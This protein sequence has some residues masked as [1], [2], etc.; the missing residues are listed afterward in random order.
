[1]TAQQR[2]VLAAVIAGV[3][4]FALGAGWQFTSARGYANRLTT[5]QA[6]LTFQRLEATL[7]AATVEA[8]RGSYE[9]A[10]QLASS[11]FTGLQ[12]DL[13][14]AP[15]DEQPF[16]DILESRDA[17]ITALSRSDPQSGSMLAQLFVRY[18]IAMG[19]PVGPAAGTSSS[20]PAAAPGTTAAPPD[21][22]P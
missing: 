1:M 11:F 14:R 19:E 15:T 2:V 13:D 4:G 20:A 16:R 10:R 3:V 6:D 18:R 5:T 21:S 22:G 17:V 9:L 12:Q 7:G 8:Q